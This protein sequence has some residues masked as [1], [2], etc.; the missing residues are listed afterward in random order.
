M[1]REKVLIVDQD[2]DTLSRIY[3]ALV[4]RKFKAE[5]CNNSQEIPE[6]LKRFKPAVIIL[7]PEDYT[8]IGRKLRIPAIVLLDD[9]SA[10]PELNYGDI[11]LKKPVT[12]D[13]VIKTLEKLI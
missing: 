8:D 10:P 1:A 5:A 4:H 3:L 6:R 9:G 13:L 12:A 2:L 11:Q 7:G